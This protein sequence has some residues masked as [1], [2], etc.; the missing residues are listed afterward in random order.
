M[1][2]KSV[3]TEQPHIPRQMDELRTEYSQMV[4]R[5]GEL[6]YQISV[7][8][9]E[10]GELQ[11]HIV[12]VNNEAAKRIELDNAAKAATTEETK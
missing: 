2:K 12:N 4:S 9:R 11:V 7:Y 1:K 6:H 3:N 10:I 5:L 8:Q